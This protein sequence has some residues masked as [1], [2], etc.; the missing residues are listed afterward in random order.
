[1]NRRLIGVCAIAVMATLVTSPVS[2]QVVPTPAALDFGVVVLGNTSFGTVTLFA[3]GPTI[4]SSLA[5]TGSDA[6]DYSVV[7]PPLLPAALPAGGTLT[8]HVAFT[9]IASGNRNAQ[10]V[11][12]TSD[13]PVIITL[14]GLGATS[15]GTVTAVATGG[16][17]ITPGA[18]TLLTGS[19]GVSC[20]WSPATGL[21][22]PT[23][24][25]T[26]ASPPSTTTYSLTVTDA[27][28][29]PSTNAP[30]V[31]VTV[32]TSLTGPPGPQGSPGPQGPAGPTAPGSVVFKGL[33]GPNDAAPPAPPGYAFIGL[34]KLDKPIG[35]SLWFAVYVK[36][37]Q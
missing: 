33:A 30:T 32:L 14:T 19:G 28:S 10:L 6:A 34:F 36:T 25:S 4:I 12:T 3:T 24:C 9:P 1:M 16:G 37:A 23:S 22:D 5:V 20:A 7:A 29:C 27:N 21:T 8:V 17:T 2:A 26:L 18:L 11:A 13:T 15:C 31:S 35:G